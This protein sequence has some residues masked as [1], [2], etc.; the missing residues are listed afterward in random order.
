MALAVGMAVATIG[1]SRRIRYR[2]TQQQLFGMAHLRIILCYFI[3]SWTGMNTTLSVAGRTL[4][5]F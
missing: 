2:G 5:W 3:E 1:I 4:W